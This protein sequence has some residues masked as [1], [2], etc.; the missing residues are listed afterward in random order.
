MVLLIC[1]WYYFSF[2]LFPLSLFFF[3]FC[4]I[5]KWL[6]SY[7]SGET[8]R[9]YLCFCIFTC[10][11]LCG[12]FSF[13]YSLKLLWHEIPIISRCFW[14]FSTKTKTPQC[15]VW[16]SDI[17][18]WRNEITLGSKELTTEIVFQDRECGLLLD[19]EW[20]QS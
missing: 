11:L 14:I 10:A 6:F 5:L 2:P 20:A 4:F 15:G 7:L 19:L 13:V 3:C 18:L 12:S 16:Y 9:L 8:F 1:S 17:G